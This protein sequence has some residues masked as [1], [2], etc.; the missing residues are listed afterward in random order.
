MRVFF[1]FIF[2]SLFCIIQA[3]GMSKQLLKVDSTILPKVFILGQHEKA[4]EKLYEQSSTVLLEV[5][6]D[7]MN[8]AFDKWL[9]MLE[10]MEAYAN[11]I[12]FDIKGIKIWLNV[13]WDQDG[14][15]EHLAF[16]LK[17]NSRN[18]DQQELSAFFSSFMNHYKF[19]VVSD[20]NFSHY[21]SAAFPTFS[22]RVKKDENIKGSVNSKK[23]SNPIKDSVG[24]Y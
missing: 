22:R 12:N 14:S 1:S 11:Q 15:I 4:Y 24:K 16:H 8:E 3:N 20:R 6:H 21:G 7:D 9:G 17:A 23:K 13:F 18:I 10:E 19:P 5:C 2:L